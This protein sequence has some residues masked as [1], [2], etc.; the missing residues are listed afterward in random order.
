M[1]SNG[2][3]KQILK[4]PELVEAM[5]AKAPGLSDEQLAEIAAVAVEG[6]RP[7]GFGDPEAKGASGA[8]DQKP[9]KPK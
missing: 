4:Q 2:T 5:R 8:A 3:A 7:P 1:T 6:Y 9:G